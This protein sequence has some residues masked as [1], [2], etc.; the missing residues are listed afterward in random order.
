TP[1][2][3]STKFLDYLAEQDVNGREIKNVV[4]VGHSLAQNARRDMKTEDLLQGMYALKQYETDFDQL[5]E[6]GEAQK[7]TEA[8][9]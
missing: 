7:T 3:L 4:R 6:Q 8:T 9:A 2:W 5:S 1:D